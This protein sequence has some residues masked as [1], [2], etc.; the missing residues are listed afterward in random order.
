MAASTL[1]QFTA[2]LRTRNVARANQYYIEIVPPM[3]FSK[4]IKG[5]SATDMN[6]VSMW[7][8]TAMTPQTNILT[9]DDYLEAGTRR[10]YAYDQDHQNLTLSFYVDQ[11]F[12]VKRFFDQWKQ[13]IVPQRRN[14]NYP[15]EYTSDSLN[16]YLLDSTGKPTYKYEYAKVF[17]KSI[18]TL[19][20]SYAS[21]T[22]PATF[23]V[24]F[25]FEEVYYSSIKSGL[26]DFTSKPDDA[27]T[28]Y[29]KKTVSNPEVEQSVTP[30]ENLEDSSW[31][32]RGKNGTRWT[33]SMNDIKGVLPY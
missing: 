1:S 26:I 25:V 2:E 12:A 8:H 24:D 6:L 31:R 30:P 3:I 19:D 27:P 29:A 5:F 23:T 10:K 32:G 13:A 4:Q 18:N 9:N 16:L 17:P 21:S 28:L 20:L 11:Q 22:S 15:E 33:G 14:F 7:C